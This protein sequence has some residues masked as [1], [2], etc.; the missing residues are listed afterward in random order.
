MCKT[1]KLCKWSIKSA[2]TSSTKT[3]EA[4]VSA[5]AMW[6]LHCQVLTEGAV[7]SICL[8]LCPGWIYDAAPCGLIKSRSCTVC[9]IWTCS[10]QSLTYHFYRNLRLHLWRSLLHVTQP[11]QTVQVVHTLFPQPALLVRVEERMHQV[12]AIILGDLEWLLLNAL[13]QTLQMVEVPGTL[14]Y[15]C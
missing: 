2:S 11:M 7:S 15:Q 8:K 10:T 6:I 9:K 14:D 3:D 5:A 4:Q 1:S 13:I 12:I